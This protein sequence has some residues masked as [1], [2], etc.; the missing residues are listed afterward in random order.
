MIRIFAAF[1]LSSLFLH[2][3]EVTV[4]VTGVRNAKG[5]V[6]ALIFDKEKGFP[7]EVKVAAHQA[8]IA[9]KPG[10]VVLKF[11]GVPAGRYAVSVLHDE[12]KN[13]KLATNF[14]GVPRE[15]V[16]VSNG[17]GNAKPKFAKALTDVK[18]GDNLTI[19]LQYP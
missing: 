5:V 7:S 16:G 4:T 6:A 9:A 17:F 14:I 15:G 18:P 1:L 2:G 11:N 12:D 3:K 13:G 8:Q 10:T 19:A